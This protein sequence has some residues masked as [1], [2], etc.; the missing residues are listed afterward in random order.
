M[1]GALPE[2]AADAAGK[3]VEVAPWSPPRVSCAGNS[4]PRR[5]PVGMVTPVVNKGSPS[6][7]SS[8]S[9]ETV[10]AVG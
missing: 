1:F 3:V 10:G 5:G 7:D 9:T 8:P 2:D 4:G 6:P